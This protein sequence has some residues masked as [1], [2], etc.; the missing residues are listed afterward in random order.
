MAATATRERVSTTIPSKTEELGDKATRKKTTRNRFS[1]RPELTML[2]NQYVNPETGEIDSQYGREFVL[3]Q[4]DRWFISSLSLP[5]AEFIKL[6]DEAYEWHESASKREKQLTIQEF[7]NNV[8]LD[9]E[10]LEMLQ[11]ELKLR[12]ETNKASKNG[13]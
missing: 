2:S 4:L 7:L 3:E 6:V 9:K 12:L 8:D 11:N 13:K 10:A 1:K 5:K